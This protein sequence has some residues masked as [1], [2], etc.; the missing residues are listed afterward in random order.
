MNRQIAR[1]ICLG[2]TP[3]CVAATTACATTLAL[4][5]HAEAASPQET[6]PAPINS[7]GRQ[8]RVV[9]FSFHDQPIDE[10]VRLVDEEGARGADLIVLPEAW[11]GQE[12]LPIDGPLMQRLA[13]L[14]KK[15]RTYI[16]NSVF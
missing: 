8:V 13:A 7:V 12:P 6:E 3:L 2:A 9:S 1:L 16:V 4:G 11:T 10:I 14:A 15:H 5:P